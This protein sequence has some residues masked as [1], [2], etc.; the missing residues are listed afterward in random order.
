MKRLF[1]LTII[2]AFVF[3]SCRKDKTDT[4]TIRI[5]RTEIT[6]ANS[7]FSTF[8]SYDAQGRLVKTSGKTNNEAEV[9]MATIIYSGNDVI[10]QSPL[11]NNAGVSETH[12]IRY[13]LNAEKKPFFRTETGTRDFN[14]APTTQHDYYKYESDYQYNI[15]GYLVKINKSSYDSTHLV[16]P[17]GT[18]IQTASA[19]SVTDFTIAANNL[20]SV[21]STT[22]TVHEI[23]SNAG[24]INFTDNKIQVWDFN[25]NMKFSNK[26]DYLNSFLLG[27]LDI[28]RL[29]WFPF[30][31]AVAYVPDLITYNESLNGQN[32][33]NNTNQ[34][35]YTYNKY[36]FIASVK[37]NNNSSQPPL[38]IFYNK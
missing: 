9:T 29:E 1:L 22:Q 30:N 5:E 14:I 13:Q 33:V 23:I 6:S 4:T 36:G 31:A 24:N 27:E 35:E 34:L 19:S 17:S 28:F 20:S 32:T 3:A 2:S 25:Y 38:K 21:R 16:Q 10:I 37:S 15:D 26:T 12:E 18:S 7:V 8:L 11:I